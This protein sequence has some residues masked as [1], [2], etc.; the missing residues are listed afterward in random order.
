MH[1]KLC[2][3]VKNWKS[4]SSDISHPSWAQR[5]SY[6][7]WVEWL[8]PWGPPAEMQWLRCWVYFTVLLP[9]P[10]HVYTKNILGQ[11]ITWSYWITP[12]LFL[13]SWKSW[14]LV[15]SAECVPSHSNLLLLYQHFAVNHHSRDWKRFTKL[16]PEV[17][18]F[19][20]SLR[21]T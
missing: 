10:G 5:P 19:F 6:Q 1:T 21:I 13:H 4:N 3:F 9:P 16:F 15:N 17:L 11:N 7:L 20:Q 18:F 12:A 8:R 14:N 2:P